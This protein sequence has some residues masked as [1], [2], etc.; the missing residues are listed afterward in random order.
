[1]VPVGC[2]DK[3]RFGGRRRE[4]LAQP[5]RGEVDEGKRVARES[6]EGEGPKRGR[7]LVNF[8]DGGLPWF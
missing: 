2:V 5:G 8:V 7:L 1:M 3:G 6:R 4:D